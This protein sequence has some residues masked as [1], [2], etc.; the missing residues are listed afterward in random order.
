MRVSINSD[1]IILTDN[2]EKIGNEL[3]AF[4]ET[5]EGLSCNFIEGEF[6]VEITIKNEK[7]LIRK[8]KIDS[9]NNFIGI[10]EAIY[11]YNQRKGKRQS[12]FLT[13]N[14]VSNIINDELKKDSRLS[15][16]DILFYFF[17]YEKIFSLITFLPE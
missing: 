9:K 5:L 12:E 13:V 3:F 11:V 10:E 1:K 2:K 14:F 6:N 16:E 15:K 4:P 8:K 7:I 17:N